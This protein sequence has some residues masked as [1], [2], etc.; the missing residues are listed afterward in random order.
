ML[1]SMNARDVNFTNSKDNPIRPWF[2]RMIDQLEVNANNEHLDW[3]SVDMFIIMHSNK[4]NIISQLYAYDGY[5][6][7]NSFPPNV[8]RTIYTDKVRERHKEYLTRRALPIGG[9][10]YPVILDNDLPDIS[11]S[12]V[13][14]ATTRINDKTVFS[15]M[16]RQ[17]LSGCIKNVCCYLESPE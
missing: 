12:N 7:G 5:Y 11:C 15:L 10:F 4:W 9:R 14:F 1:F 6:D 8:S 2:K 13:Y 17:P 3:N 16:I